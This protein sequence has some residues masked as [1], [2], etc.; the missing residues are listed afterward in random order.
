MWLLLVPLRRLLLL[1]FLVVPRSHCHSLTVKRSKLNTILLFSKS[2]SLHAHHSP[3]KAEKQAKVP[4]Q[5][6]K[7]VPEE[8]EDEMEEDEEEAEEEEEAEVTRETPIEVV[9]EV[10]APRE[11]PKPAGAK[12]KA[13]AEEVTT[14]PLPKRGD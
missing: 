13:R 4:E 3:R 10:V 14:R 12:P 5:A 8:N 9:A 1:R 2:P 6:P 7:P 11:V